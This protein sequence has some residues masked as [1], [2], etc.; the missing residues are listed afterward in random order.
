MEK[1]SVSTSHRT[2]A[3]L[4][5]TAGILEMITFFFIPAYS[6]SWAGNTIYSISPFSLLWNSAD[7]EYYPTACIALIALAVVGSLA[8]LGFSI[9]ALIN[10][11]MTST[12][13]IAFG[14]NI[15]FDLALIPYFF[16]LGSS[17]AGDIYYS[18]DFFA[19]IAYFLSIIILIVGTVFLSAKSPAPAAAP[20]G[21]AVPYDPALSL[22][23][24]ST[25]AITGLD[26]S[27]ALI[28][29]RMNTQEHFTVMSTFPSTILGR[30]TTDANIVVGGNGLIGRQHA[31]INY[32]EGCFYIT[33]LNSKNKTYLNDVCLQPNARYVLKKGDYIT[34]ANEV[35]AVNDI[36]NC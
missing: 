17:I 33:D 8:C 20:V 3:A 26:P 34:L 5:L 16:L 11:A 27:Q 12:R 4:T 19:I 10:P 25:N 2:G 6:D 36:K 9:P 28:L 15:S 1:Q 32:Q 7:I 30:S 35:F 23:G 22:D 18:I 31:R 24:G 21:P 13:G 14:I 29:V